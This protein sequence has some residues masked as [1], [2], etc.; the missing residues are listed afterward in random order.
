MEQ[1][2]KL[3]LLKAFGYMKNI[4]RVVKSDFFGKDLFF[5]IR[6]QH[7]MSY[8]LIYVLCTKPSLRQNFER[9][10]MQLFNPYQHKHNV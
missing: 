10:N 2:M 1:I 4:E 6:A 5:I 8:L 7:A 9:R 3:D